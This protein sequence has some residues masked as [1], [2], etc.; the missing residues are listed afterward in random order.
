[1]VTCRLPRR[2]QLFT[3]PSLAFSIA[4]ATLPSRAAAGPVDDPWDGNWH[5]SFTPYAWL[6]GIRAETTF[7]LP[8]SGARV[9]SKSDSGLLSKL[10]GALMLEGVARKGDWGL[11]G[12]VDW[13][14]FSDESGHF[15]SIGN[16]RFGADAGLRDRSGTK[17]GMFNLAGLYRLGH[18][19]QGHA[20][21]LV[22]M[23]YLW[24]KGNLS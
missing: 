4:L 7:Q 22:G 8:D 15:T 13:V 21:L 2:A 11:F 3:L 19:N 14:K 12:D 10:S 18:G 24:L 5:G 23:H 9:T 16:A 6:P 17:G 20:D 1:M